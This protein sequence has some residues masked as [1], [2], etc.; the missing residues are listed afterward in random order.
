[1]ENASNGALPDCQPFGC[2]NLKAVEG[3]GIVT[4]CKVMKLDDKCDVWCEFGYLPVI[5][6]RKMQLNTAIQFKCSAQGIKPIFGQKYPLRPGFE[7]T[8]VMWVFFYVVSRATVFFWAVHANP[9]VHIFF[10][11][12]FP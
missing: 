10:V 5:D 9:S 8:P 4:T 12:V 1:M 7:S 11:Y 2:R 3:A 6:G